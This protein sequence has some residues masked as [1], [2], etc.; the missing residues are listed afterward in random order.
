MELPPNV[1]LNE[2]AGLVEKLRNAMAKNGGFCPCRIRHTPENMCICK[3][4][5][6]QIADLCLSEGIDISPGNLDSSLCFL[7]PSISHDIL[8]I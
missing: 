6:E 7:Q 8:C 3:E 4:F 2:D 5:R 1:R